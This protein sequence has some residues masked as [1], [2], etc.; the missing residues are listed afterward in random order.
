LR[1]TGNTQ[2]AEEL[3]QECFFDLARHASQIRTSLAGWLHQAATNRALNRMRDERRRMIREREAEQRRLAL[4]EEQLT[5]DL[6]WNEIEPLVDKA[7]SE[8]P[9]DLRAPVLM[10]YLEGVTQSDI[11]T[12]LGVHQ[13]TV[14]RR[15][16][17]GLEL[18]RV[19]LRKAGFVVPVSV[20]ISG[21]ASC[22]DPRRSSSLC[23]AWGRSN[24]RCSISNARYFSVSDGLRCTGNSTSVLPISSHSSRR[25]GRWFWIAWPDEFVPSCILYHEL[26]ETPE[27]SVQPTFAQTPM[28][29]VQPGH[30]VFSTTKL[31]EIKS[32]G[33][34]SDYMGKVSLTNVRLSSSATIILQCNDQSAS[35]YIPQDAIGYMAMT[36]VST[37]V[38]VVPDEFDAGIPTRLRVLLAIVDGHS[39]QNRVE[40]V[41]LPLPKRLTPDEWRAQFAF[42]ELA[43]EQSY[44]LGETLELGSVKGM[45]LKLTV[46]PKLYSSRTEKD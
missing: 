23:C 10:H 22:N 34:E 33:L 46:K 40:G 39:R 43:T 4:A 37:F 42:R 31:T 36:G 9:E 5:T 29:E 35:L 19:R 12:A 44:L 25:L 3:T 17:D 24:Y 26:F 1:I 18:L 15:L 27:F 21:I 32:G 30:F 2:D 8:I 13:S 20:L 11:A 6:S 45:K 41:Q 38:Q 28:L 16:S 14:S 7:L